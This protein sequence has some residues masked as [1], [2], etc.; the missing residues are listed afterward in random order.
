M[1]VTSDVSGDRHVTEVADLALELVATCLKFEVPHLPDRPLQ[2]R[3]GI[4][5]GPCVAGN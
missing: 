1:T 4:N 5:T 3:I 2:I